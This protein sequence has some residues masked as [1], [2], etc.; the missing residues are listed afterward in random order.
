LRIGLDINDASGQPAQTLSLFQMLKNDVLVDTFSFDGTGNVPAGNNGNGYADYLLSGFTSFVAS[1][2]LQFHFVFNDGN[3]GTENVFLIGADAPAV[4]IGGEATPVPEPASLL[5]L[6]SGLAVVA[7][8]V[9][10]K[11]TI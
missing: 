10:K 1:D 7:R 11:V 2:T 9:R 8:R 5:L 6:G 3:S 4:P